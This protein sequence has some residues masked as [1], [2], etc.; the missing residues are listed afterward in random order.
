[1]KTGSRDLDDRQ[2]IKEALAVTEI[3][4][5]HGVSVDETDLMGNTALMQAAGLM[6]GE[7]ISNL[8]FAEYVFAYSLV[9]LIISLTWTTRFRTL[10]RG[11]ADVNHRNRQV[12]IAV[13]QR[14]PSRSF[15]LHFL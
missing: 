1:M 14:F 2:K 4:V 15:F 3:L 9:W 13:S 11:G 12:T 7:L 8:E 5:Q 10:I 6:N